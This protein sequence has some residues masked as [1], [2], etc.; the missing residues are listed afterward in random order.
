MTTYGLTDKKK[1]RQNLHLAIQRGL[2]ENDAL[3]ALTTVP[4]RLCGVE[5]LV[6]TIEPGKLADLT[7]VEGA[8]YFDPEA[9]V[10]EVWVDG[11]VYRSPFEEPKPAKTDEPKAAKASTPEEGDPN[12][13]KPEAPK[14]NVTETAKQEKKAEPASTKPPEEKKDGKKQQLRELQK[15]RTARAPLEGRGIIA[16][17]LSVIVENATVW[18]CGEQGVLTNTSIRILAGKIEKVGQFKAEADANTLVVDG[19][20]LHVT[21]GLIDCHSH[22]AILGAV[23]E[24]TLPSTA[25]VRIQ[26]VVNSETENLYNQLAGGVTA[27]NLLHGSRWRRPERVGLRGG[28]SGDKV[29]LRRKREAVELGG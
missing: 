4:A 1:F 15:T 9:K 5:D 19:K 20:G 23:N 14:T 13:P 6:G 3:A 7:V 10:R 22:T 16:G 24:S 18:T 11:R 26:D 28:S 2:S 25:M 12:K 17:P 21:P 29:R 27:V 8:G